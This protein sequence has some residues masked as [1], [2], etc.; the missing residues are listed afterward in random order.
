MKIVE[1]KAFPVTV[2]SSLNG[3]VGTAG[4]VGPR[5][6]PGRYAR[7]LPY[8]TLFSTFAETVF[9]RLRTD[10]GIV[11]WGESQAPVANK[12]VAILVEELLSPVLLGRDPRD[13]AVLRDDMYNSMRDRGHRGGFMLDAIAGADMALWDICGKHY[14]SSVAR[15]LG[16][17]YSTRLPVYLSGPRGSSVDERLD[18]TQSFVEQ[19][20]RAVK[21]FIGRG[22]REDLAEVRAFRDRFGADL[23]IFVDAQ[24]RYSPADALL[25]GRAL[26]NLGVELFETPINAEDIEGNAELARALDVAIALGETERT[27]WEVMPYLDRRAVDVLQPDVGR[28]G[29]SETMRI[30]FM[31]DLKNVPVALHCGVGF[32]PYIAATL[33]VA[34]AIPNLL[35]VEYQPEMQDL[36]R[37]SYGFRLE[38][39]DGSVLLPD[40]PGLGIEAPDAALVPAG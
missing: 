10:D 30:A 27:R 11:G 19:G 26:E 38:L 25:V 12:A 16:G 23:K 40:A 5:S 22:V 8:R 28:S 20:F 3:H 29:I 33:Q 13:P 24:W 2:E 36:A 15:L 39:K 31:A 4:L 21:L 14:G 18:D 32:G 37:E 6:A 17:A 35:Y 9:V 1:V 34:A 7:V